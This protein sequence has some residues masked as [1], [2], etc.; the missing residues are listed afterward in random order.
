MTLL[1]VTLGLALLWG[2]PAF[3][4][5][6]PAT[7]PPAK[8]A[9]PSSE[10]KEIANLKLD[11]LIQTKATLQERTDRLAAENRLLQND[12]SAFRSRVEAIQAEMNRLFGC[13]YDLDA[14]QCAQDKPKQ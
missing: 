4:D 6:S 11:L 9:E 14:R 2:Q 7:K 5:D 12:V 13:N 8:K 10:Q 3:P 1:V